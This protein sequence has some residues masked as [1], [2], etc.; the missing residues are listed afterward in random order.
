MEIINACMCIFR[1]NFQ[2][3]W[4]SLLLKLH[5]AMVT[6]STGDRTTN[7]S[8][9]HTLWP[10]NHRTYRHTHTHTPTHTYT[11]VIRELRCLSWDT[12]L[13]SYAVTCGS[14]WIWAHAGRNS[15]ADDQT[16]SYFGESMKSLQCSVSSCLFPLAAFCLSIVGLSGDT[17]TVCKKNSGRQGPPKCL[18]QRKEDPVQSPA[19]C[20][21]LSYVGECGGMCF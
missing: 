20:L 1:D 21:Y 9:V 16:R 2:N 10:I 13:G 3:L 8:T 7:N 4:P 5:E 14:A 17:Q 18:L 19:G 15:A 11:R 12:V 6:K